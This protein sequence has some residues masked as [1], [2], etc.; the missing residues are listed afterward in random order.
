MAYEFD[1]YYDMREEFIYA[2]DSQHAIN[3]D[4]N[5]YDPTGQIGRM[6]SRG[7]SKSKITELLESNQF[8][9]K[10]KELLA[11]EDQV[12]DPIERAVLILFKELQQALSGL[13]DPPAPIDVREMAADA[14]E[15]SYEGSDGPAQMIRDGALSSEVF[16][17]LDGVPS[18]SE[19]LQDFL[20][21]EY[22]ENTQNYQ[23]YRWATLKDIMDIIKDIDLYK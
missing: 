6:A 19:A 3:A 2:L 15:S 18:W 13:G 1:E 21:R 7:D 10:N 16:E 12:Q 4:F 8:Y 14:L 20:T 23:I 9:R 5:P 11:D 17:A 22:V